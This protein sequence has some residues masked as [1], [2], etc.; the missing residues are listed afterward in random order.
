[1][2]ELRAIRAFERIEQLKAEKLWSFRQPRK[3]RAGAVPKSHWDHL[4]DEMVR[5]SLS[6]EI[7][8]SNFVF[9]AMAT[10]RLSTGAAVEESDRSQSCASG[11]DLASSVAYRT[12]R[13]V[14][15]NLVSDS[16]ARSRIG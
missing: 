6:N 2:E 12:N 14:S 8:F 16:T 1:M 4:L 10:D 15:Q 11:A 9:A 5:F 13:A 7:E 3:Q